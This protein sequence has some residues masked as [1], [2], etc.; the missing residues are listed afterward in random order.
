MSPMGLSWFRA[1]LGESPAAGQSLTAAARPASS[2]ATHPMAAPRQGPPGLLGPLGVVARGAAAV[3]DLGAVG[4]QRGAHLPPLLEAARVGH[5]EA[6]PVPDSASRGIG[7]ADGSGLLLPAVGAGGV[8]GGFAGHGVRRGYRRF[9]VLL[10]AGQRLPPGPRRA[11]HAGP[12]SGGGRGAFRHLGLLRGEEGEGGLAA[13]QAAPH[14]PGEPGNESSAARGERSAPLG[15]ARKRRPPP[16][17]AR[18]VSG[19]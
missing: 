14:F 3:E 8:G 17:A 19:K 13:G 6:P 18:T 5:A 7:A 16:C 1:D 2:P 10:L 9:L 4:Q 15:A 12:S 11:L